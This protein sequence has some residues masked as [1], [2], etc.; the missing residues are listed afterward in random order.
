MRLIL[1]GQYVTKR[2]QRRRIK[3]THSKTF[4]KIGRIYWPT[5]TNSTIPI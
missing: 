4:E 2:E 1:K 5:I 3:T